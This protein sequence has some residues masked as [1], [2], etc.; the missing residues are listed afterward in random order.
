MNNLLENFRLYLLAFLLPLLLSLALTPLLRALALRL[1][2]LDKPSDIKTHKIP[3][4]LFGGAA[5]FA[6]FTITLLVMRFYTSFP[7]GTLRDLRL[8]L[9]GGG[10]MFALG[11][12]DDLLKPGGLGVRTKFAV[13]F[14]VALVTAYYGIRIHFIQPD[15]VAFALSVLWIVGV[16]NAF[17]IID[18]KFWVYCKGSTFTSIRI[19]PFFFAHQTIVLCIINNSVMY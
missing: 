19:G 17:N 7:T 15:H 13:Q 10:I 14:A 1:G 11:F 8:I 4:P 18:I 5:I 6:S 9:A 12:V 2:Q 3:T 16:S